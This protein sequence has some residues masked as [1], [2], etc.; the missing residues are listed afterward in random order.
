MTKFCL[1]FTYSEEN[2][3]AICILKHSA[4]NI[5]RET[6]ERV[7]YY[8]ERGL[9]NYRGSILERTYRRYIGCIKIILLS[10]WLE[11]ARL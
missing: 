9:T 7:N 11:S 4:S 1:L 8:L 10:A 2:N 3:N 5:D 6:R